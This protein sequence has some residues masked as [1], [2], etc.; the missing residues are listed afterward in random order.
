MGMPDTKTPRSLNARKGNGALASAPAGT[1][2]K[3]QRPDTHASSNLGW[4]AACRTLTIYVLS[5]FSSVVK[6]LPAV[7]I[8]FSNG[9]VPYMPASR[10]G[11]ASRDASK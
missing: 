8:A 4:D 6:R 1:L 7:W 3:C 9:I 2:A 10:I 11:M 5:C